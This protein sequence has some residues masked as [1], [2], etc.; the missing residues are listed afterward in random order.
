MKC[1]GSLEKS[2]LELN[3]SKV[4][5]NSTSH[6]FLERLIHKGRNEIIT[7]KLQMLETDNK[8]LVKLETLS[9]EL[10]QKQNKFEFWWTMVASGELLKSKILDLEKAIKS[11]ALGSKGL[12]MDLSG[13]QFAKTKEGP[14]YV[15][16]AKKKS[17]D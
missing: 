1:S 8:K 10:S 2:A 6:G 3:K 11:F 14:R 17:L 7:D 9:S 4:M 5:S 16:S 12:N 13:Q 15:Y